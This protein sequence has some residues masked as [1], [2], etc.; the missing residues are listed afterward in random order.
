MEVDKTYFGHH[1]TVCYLFHIS[2][3]KWQLNHFGHHVIVIH[4]SKP[5]HKSTP[6]GKLK[7]VQAHAC[8]HC[9][10]WLGTP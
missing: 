4:H 10:K 2:V 7:L 9:F 8:L 3:L 5:R 1:P 6:F